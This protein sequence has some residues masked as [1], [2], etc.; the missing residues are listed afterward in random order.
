MNLKPNILIFSV[1]Q[2]SVSKKQNEIN[3]NEVLKAIQD[4][5]ISAMELQGRYNGSNELSILVSG[6]EH[7]ALVEH[8]CKAFNQESYLESHN[9]RATFLIYK[10]GRRESIGTLTPVSKEEAESSIGY[11]Y[12]PLVDQYFI[13]K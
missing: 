9:D 11:S 5:G 1:F 6:F 4:K 8:T 13:A 7:R 2:N 12:N 10:D 3:H